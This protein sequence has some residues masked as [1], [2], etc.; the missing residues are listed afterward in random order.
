MV[1]DLAKHK[2]QRSKLVRIL[3]DKGIRDEKVLKAIS[4]I[5]RHVFLDS[6][7]EEFAYQDKPFP[8]GAGQ[9]ISQP[10]TV[11]FQTELLQLQKGEKVL[12]VGTGSGYQAA[13]LAE[14]GAKVYTIE[15][16]K[17]LFDKTKVL[18]E[19][20]G[21]KINMKFG[22]GYQGMPSYAPYDKIIVTAGAPELPQELVKQL[23]VGGRMVIPLGEGSQKMKLILKNSET[24]IVIEDHGDFRFVPM[25]GNKNA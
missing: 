21:Y 1:Y 2:G 24:D 15:R 3:I 7:F 16:Q 13:V 10:Y 23:K 22:D 6:S 14:I 25:L 8:I 17:E 9:T 18:L 11:A 12:E 5:P 4:R 19:R 20:L